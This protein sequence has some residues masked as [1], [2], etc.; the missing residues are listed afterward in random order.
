MFDAIRNNKRLVQIFLLFITVPFAVW[1]LDAYFQGGGDTTLATIGKTRITTIEFR[2]ALREQQ[3]QWRQQM[4]GADVAALNTPELRA[5]LLEDMVMRR[6]LLLEAKRLRLDVRGLMRETIL[7][8]PEFQENGA[9]SQD[10]YSSLLSMNNMSVQEFEARLQE[11]MLQQTL[12]GAVQG[13]AFA[14]Q[15]VARRIAALQKETRVVEESLMTWQSLLGQVVVTE[16]EARQFYDA[17]APRFTLPEQIRVEY[18]ALSQKELEDK[19]RLDEK[20]V[21][22]WYDAHKEQFALRVEKRRASHILVPGKADAEALLAEVK[23]NPERFAELAKSKSTDTGSA[24][25]GGDLGFFERAGMV[26]PFADAAFALKDGEI[27]GVVESEF[28]FHIIRLTGIQ[29]GQYRSFADARADVEAELKREGAARRFAESA[30]KFANLIY[31]QFDSLKPAADAF[32]LVVR[33]S[34]WLTREVDPK[35][36]DDVLQSA[37]LRSAMFDDEVLKNGRN[38]KAVEAMPGVMASARLLEHRPAALVPFADA[39]RDIQT[40]LRQEKAQ[41]LAAER[42]K[43]NLAELEKAGANTSAKSLNARLNLKWGKPQ[44]ISREDPG[45]LHPLS[46]NAIFRA[47]GEQ[48]PPVYT[49]VELPGTG[50]ALYK[51]NRVTAGEVQDD[52]LAE[53]RQQLTRINA[54]TQTNAYLAALRQRYAVEIN[55][56]KLQ[57]EGGKD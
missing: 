42:G 13:G 36:G 49:G 5:A 27:S 10:R 2:E 47:P 51:I 31:E 1:G 7:N 23:Q 50:Y 12:L 22:A 19:N 17:N 55:E 35:A 43:A 48:K 6:I 24:Q 38:A 16:A 45:K 26:E 25:Q 37:S 54:Q 4:P 34:G 28:G 41:A 56:K 20:T 11:N 33:Q 46:I 30:E 52:V 15:T 14:P 53:T 40:F 44:S 32:G 18:L 39:Q 9:F 57:E 29:P 21:R 8:A 3:D